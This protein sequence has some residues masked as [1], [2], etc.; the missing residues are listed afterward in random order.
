MK[1]AMHT[2]CFLVL[3]AVALAAWMPAAAAQARPTATVATPQQAGSPVAKAPT[4][5]NGTAAAPTAAAPVPTAGQQAPLAAAPSD[6]DGFAGCSATPLPS[7]CTECIAKAGGGRVIEPICAACAHMP[8]GAL[9]NYCVK[10]ATTYGAK[11]CTG[12]VAASKLLRVINNGNTP[13]PSEVD[14]AAAC[15]GC[16]KRTANRLEDT[17]A[18]VPCYHSGDIFQPELCGACVA[19]A[20]WAKQAD[21]CTTACAGRE[22]VSSQ[23]KCFECALSVPDWDSKRW[24]GL[25]TGPSQDILTAQRL[26]SDHV[27]CLRASPN[28]LGGELCARCGQIDSVNKGQR[29]MDCLVDLFGQGLSRADLQLRGSMCAR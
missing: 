4:P 14:A 29:C 25:S 19:Q 15:F 26:Y 24:C 10:C 7:A 21:I 2:T 3:G 18:C 8:T 20:N 13:E 23:K 22:P 9:R 5:L 12:C 28:D 6:G 1:M 16:Y 27:H 17:S 11:G